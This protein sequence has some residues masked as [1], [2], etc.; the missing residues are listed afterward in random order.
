MHALGIVV[1]LA[2]AFSAAVVCTA[3][4]APRDSKQIGTVLESFLKATSR[5]DYV[6]AYEYFSEARKDEISEGRFKTEFS[7]DPAFA[8]FAGLKQIALSEQGMDLRGLRERTY[9]GSV[10]YE[11]GSTANLAAS[12]VLQGSKWKIDSV[13]IG[14]VIL[15]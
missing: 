9:L 2:I 8:G 12:L 5:G 7:A 10:I 6:S 13:E 11:D 4:A 1:A 14:R 15:D 3:I